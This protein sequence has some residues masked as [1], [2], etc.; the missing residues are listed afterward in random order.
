M[1]GRRLFF[2]LCLLSASGLAYGQLMNTESFQPNDQ[3]LETTNSSPS[4]TPPP[5]DLLQLWTEFSAKYQAFNLSL[6]QFLDQVEAFGINFEDLPLYLE[7][8]TTSYAESE[9]SRKALVDALAAE[10]KRSEEERVVGGRW[11]TVAVVAA[12]VGVAGWVA[13]AFSRR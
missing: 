12:G 4:L 5:N 7:F 1:C 10:T 3:P 6:E 9:A 2:L 13:F 11:R 8:L